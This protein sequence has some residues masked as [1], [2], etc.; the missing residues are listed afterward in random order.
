MPQKA[1][2]DRK[3]DLAMLVAAKGDEIASLTVDVTDQFPSNEVHSHDQVVGSPQCLRR[4]RSCEGLNPLSHVIGLLQDLQIE[5]TA[6][7]SAEL[8]A[9]K[10]KLM[11][12]GAKSKHRMTAISTRMCAVDS[13][14]TQNRQARGLSVD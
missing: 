6:D 11:R 9:F 4:C 7:T 2:Q 12:S 3:T 14:C 8:D 1:E 5:A 10:K 13:E